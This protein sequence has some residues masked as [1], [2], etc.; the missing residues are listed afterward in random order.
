MRRVCQFGVDPNGGSA[1][2]FQGQRRSSG[3]V[4]LRSTQAGGGSFWG[5]ARVF[6]L[7]VFCDS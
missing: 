5:S 7:D 6:L 2:S 4:G 1:I 3:G